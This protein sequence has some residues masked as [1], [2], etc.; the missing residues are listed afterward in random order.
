MEED[1]T[2]EFWLF[3]SSSYTLWKQNLALLVFFIRLHNLCRKAGHSTDPALYLVERAL[4]KYVLF[5]GRIW[6]W[7]EGVWSREKGKG[8]KGERE[9][10]KGGRKRGRG[11]EQ[12]SVSMLLIWGKLWEGKSECGF[13][14]LPGSL[15]PSIS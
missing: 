4:S 2:S 7:E 6:I 1:G 10:K 15:A 3:S 9:E 8:R 12:E 13:E 5:M 11:R 14:L